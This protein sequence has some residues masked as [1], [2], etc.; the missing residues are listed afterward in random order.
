MSRRAE[1]PQPPSWV[2]TGGRDGAPKGTPGH[3]AA[4]L[5]SWGL[6]GR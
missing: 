5:F 3:P 6:L 1:S 4:W 2:G